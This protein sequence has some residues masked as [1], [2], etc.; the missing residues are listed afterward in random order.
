MKDKVAAVVLTYRPASDLEEN[1]KKIIRQVDHV[2]VINNE[3][4]GV[5]P[6]PSLG[7]DP[8]VSFQYNK[9]NLGVATGFNQGIRYALDSLYDYVILFD[10]DSVPGENMVSNLLEFSQKND[11]NPLIVGPSLFGAKSQTRMSKEESKQFQEVK[12]II[13]SG[14]MLSR[15]TIEWIG[16][17]DEQ[18]FIDYVDHDICLKAKRLGASVYKLKEAVLYH[19]FGAS[20]QKDVLGRSIHLSC[21]PPVRHYFR[22]RNFLALLM[23]Y[24]DPVWA[25]NEMIFFCK[26]WIKIILFEDQIIK[27]SVAVLKGVWSFLART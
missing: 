7:H 26:E 27:K 11:S 20:Q 4:D 5:C 23:R 8:R 15:S 12:T 1:I 6:C 3:S 19:S 21:Y 13:S 25:Y 9:L 24:R 2:F 18:L 16:I 10:Q 22:S 17:H 14:M